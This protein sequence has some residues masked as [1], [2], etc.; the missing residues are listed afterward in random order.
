MS[1]LSA[2]E[3]SK[4]NAK[5]NYPDQRRKEH[6]KDAFNYN[7]FIPL[8]RLLVFLSMLNQRTKHTDKGPR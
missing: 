5:K 7:P 3:S 8:S 2:N 6:A 1:N 4:I